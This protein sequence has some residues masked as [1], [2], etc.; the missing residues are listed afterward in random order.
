MP[1]SPITVR[2]PNGNIINVTKTGTIHLG[3]NLILKN[4]L[5]IP[6]FEF[7]LLSVSRV[8]DDNSCYATFNSNNCLFQDHSIGRVMALGSMVEGLYF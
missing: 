4:V 8:C 2:L 7:N 3:Q 5:Y 6:K 1:E